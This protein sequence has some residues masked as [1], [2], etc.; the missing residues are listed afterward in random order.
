MA[1]F[2]MINPWLIPFAIVPLLL[3]H[4]SLAVQKLEVEARVDPKTG[5]FNARHFTTVFQ[6][7][8]NRAQRFQR[9]M[10][11]I[12]AD[13]D[14]L[15][16]INN[17]YGHLAGDAVLRGIADVFRREFRAYDVPA[18]FGG[19]EFS[20]LL[21]ETSPEEALEIAD[22]VR[23]AVADRTYEVETSSEPIRATISMGVAAFPRDGS[24]PN[25]L[26]HA[27]DV[28]VYRAKLQGRN[29]VLDAADD[30]T[31]LAHPAEHAA[32]L[33]SLPMPA[34]EAQRPAPMPLVVAPAPVVVTAP[35]PPP[36][37]PT[38]T[39]ATARPHTPRRAAL[40]VDPEASRA[41]RRASSA[42]SGRQPASS[43]PS[44]A[45]RRTTSGSRSWWRSSVSARRCR[46]RWRRPAQSL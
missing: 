45:T 43:A 25:E 42:P 15:R 22:R 17:T 29:R 24:E 40:P 4:R 27:A 8:L 19:E 41:L 31:L 18:R 34:A 10:S 39:A 36:G 1:S 46:S 9:P 7:E 13:L 21:P 38:R 11:L 37:A 6:E 2:W 14:L 44:S 32:S 5:L 12:M 16:D 33:V 30:E 28:A 26:V 35:A 23:R 3:I 20:I